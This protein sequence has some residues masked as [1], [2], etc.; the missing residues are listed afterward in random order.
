MM[1]RCNPIQ[2]EHTEGEDVL[3]RSREGEGWF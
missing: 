3:K 1:E 2:E